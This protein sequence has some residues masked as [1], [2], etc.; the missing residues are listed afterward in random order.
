MDRAEL[1]KAVWQDQLADRELGKSSAQA[2]P[3]ALP[4]KAKLGLQFPA[5]PKVCC[6]TPLRDLTSAS[7]GRAIAAQR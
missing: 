5:L 7:S 1:A 6:F 4:P 3:P 2:Q